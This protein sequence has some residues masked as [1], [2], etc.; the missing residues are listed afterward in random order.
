MGAPGPDAR[1][2]A[3][4]RGPRLVRA[5]SRSH[6]GNAGGNPI[7]SSDPPSDDIDARYERVRFVDADVERAPASELRVRIQLSAEDEEFL[8]ERRGTGAGVVE[9][10]LAVKATLDALAEAVPRG[11]RLKLVGVK[12]VR[13]FDGEA[14]MVG[15]RTARPAGKQLLGCVPVGASPA[16]AAAT[17]TLD[18]VNRILGRPHL[19]A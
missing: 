10:R 7:P 11:P 5:A 19:D 13:A 12:S 3:S 1:G 17:A 18:A 8:G 14:V 16:R 9:L 2:G 4:E 6:P 15:L